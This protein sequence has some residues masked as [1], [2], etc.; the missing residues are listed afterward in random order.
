MAKNARY[1][2]E[3]VGRLR[4]AVNTFKEARRCADCGKKWRFW[5]LQFDH[6]GDDKVADVAVLVCHGAAKK[7]WEEIA[8][9]EVVCAN[10][11]TTRTHNRRVSA[12]LTSPK[13]LEFRQGVHRADEV[14]LW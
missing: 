6:I 11:H 12:N 14:P 13:R 2:L 1:K 9:C 10:C 5:Q 7:V 4:E 8:K 3:S